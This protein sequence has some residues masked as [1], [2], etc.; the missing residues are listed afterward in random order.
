MTYQ[1][2]FWNERMDF[3]CHINNKHIIF[4]SCWW[5]N[6]VLP[7]KDMLLYSLT[8]ILER[9]TVFYFQISIIVCALDFDAFVKAKDFLEDCFFIYCLSYLWLTPWLALV[10]AKNFVT[11]GLFLSIVCPICGWPPG[12]FSSKQRILSLEDCFYLLF[13]L[14]V[15]D[16]L[17]GSP[18]SKGFCHWR[19]V[20]ICCLSYLWLT[21]WLVLLK[22]K[23]F[24]TGGLFFINCLSY[25]WL[26]PWLALV[27]AKSFVT[28]RLSLSI[29][30]PICGWPPG[31]F[32][33]KQ[34]ILSLEDCFYLLFVLS[35]VDSLVG[36]RQSK[37]FCHWRIVFYLLF[38][39][40]VA[41][42]WVGSRQSEGFCHWR[43]V[44]SVVCPICSWPSCSRQSTNPKDPPWI[45]CASFMTSGIL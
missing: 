15:V 42:P 17:V 19:T 13:V 36:S 12:W 35:V 43:T 11:G 29:V 26:T 3:V 6:S 21:P 1:N 30:C 38:V 31:W 4:T 2:S 33:S 45:F 23:D 9:V 20:F 16:S 24:V 41:D 27:K 18:Q 7:W 32:S 39:L 37:G 14:S 10:K 25:L 34:R 5:K 22:A 44:L 40:S 28:G 8:F